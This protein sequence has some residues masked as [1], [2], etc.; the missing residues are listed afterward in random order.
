[1]LQPAVRFAIAV[2]PATVAVVAEPS[3]AGAL[4]A[5]YGAA[6][7]LP[8]EAVLL[9]GVFD[10]RSGAVTTF[11]STDDV[12][13]A[14]NSEDAAAV[15]DALLNGGAAPAGSGGRR[16]ARALQAA[17][18]QPNA[19]SIAGLAPRRNASSAG[20]ALFFNALA[21]CAPPCSDAQITAASIALRLRV[22]ATGANASLLAGVL[23]PGVGWALN[24]RAVVA[25]AL[26]RVRIRWRLWA[27]LASLPAWVVAVSA[28][29]S[30][31]ACC[32]ALAALWLRRRRRARAEKVAPEELALQRAASEG[33]AG[34]AKYAA[35][36]AAGTAGSSADEPI[37]WEETAPTEAGA[38]LR[39]WGGGSPPGSNPH[40]R[41]AEGLP[42]WDDEFA[43]H[44]RRAPLR[45]G[46]RHGQPPQPLALAAPHARG[47]ASPQR[48][49]GAAA[50]RGLALPPP[51]ARAA[52]AASRRPA[53]ALPGQSLAWQRARALADSAAAAA[54]LAQEA[55]EAAEAEEEDLMAGLPE[56]MEEEERGLGEEG[57][58]AAA[59]LALPRS[60]S[61]PISSGAVL[62][63]R[64]SAVGALEL[65]KKRLQRPDE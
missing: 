53:L 25:F 3:F 12:N 28:S 29:L 47:P 56:Q 42:S 65:L 10:V 14:G 59:P 8:I 15:L 43:A 31:L 6:L 35:A 50:L 11:L 44:A 49:A 23:P 13:V 45:R 19:L 22:L 61:G 64:L 2:E 41:T 46:T 51:A 1:V 7:A 24:D 54:R 60:P 9:A 30:S 36:P 52:A 38:R 27:W 63:S 32:A 37:G 20:V 16:R 62:Q 4:R 55:A 57:G 21:P 48:A 5:A 39:A 58:E 33:E 40:T 18:A 26:P 34:L 17:P